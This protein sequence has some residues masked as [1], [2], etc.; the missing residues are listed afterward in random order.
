M[1]IYIL[2]INYG[3]RTHGI[4]LLEAVST[5]ECFDVQCMQTVKFRKIFIEVSAYGDSVVNVV[6]CSSRGHE[7]NAFLCSSC[8]VRHYS[9]SSL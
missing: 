4:K 5:V 9:L 1:K 7:L 3:S 8:P 6:A 2:V